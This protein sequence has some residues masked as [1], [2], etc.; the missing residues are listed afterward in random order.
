MIWMEKNWKEHQ[1]NEPKVEKT[2]SDGYWYKIHGQ[3]AKP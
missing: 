1:N 3:E 2:L